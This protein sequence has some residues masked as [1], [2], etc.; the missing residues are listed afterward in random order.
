LGVEKFSPEPT[1][2]ALL[3]NQT[4][5]FVG[6]LTAKG[7]GTVPK[8]YFKVHGAPLQCSPAGTTGSAI[9]NCSTRNSTNESAQAGVWTIDETAMPV[10][11]QTPMPSPSPTQTSDAFP[12]AESA[13]NSGIQ[14]YNSFAS[15]K[16]ECLDAF[17]VSKPDQK[18]LMSYLNSK[19]ICGSEDSTVD[20]LYKVLLGSRPVRSSI[21]DFA[22]LANRLNAISDEI[23]SS[24]AVV[25]EGT[26]M[27]SEVLT[28]TSS[29]NLLD[30]YLQKMESGFSR[31]EKTIIQLPKKIS[32][33]LRLNSVFE[34]FE[35]YKSFYED[36]RQELN[37]TI[38]EIKKLAY[39]DTNSI[40]ET[41]FAIQSILSS[42]PSQAI[43]DRSINR[44]ID[45]IPSFYC[46]R[47]KDSRLPISGKCQSGYVKSTIKKY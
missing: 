27:A 11:S 34:D 2:S 24:A 4:G 13:Y 37:S 21:V 15:I 6:I 16:Q 45:S 22:T 32:D 42:L 23:E 33:T 10:P 36:G 38:D 43:F 17:R 28:L 19:V 26:S 5:S 44:T 1:G 40:Q 18:K 12:L 31:V 30:R 8:E 25:S 29:F 39:P 46:K 20:N 3:F 47:G 41:K 14:A 35:D 7:I 9:T